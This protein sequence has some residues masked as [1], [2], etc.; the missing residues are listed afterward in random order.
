MSELELF[1]ETENFT[2]VGLSEHWLKPN[3]SEALQFKN[4][5]VKSHFSRPD[6]SHGGSMIL[7]QKP[8][9]CFSLDCIKLLSLE[10]HCEI[11]AI[12]LSK[13]NLVV[14]NIYR[15]PS[16][17]FDLFLEIL[18]ELFTNINSLT[19]NIILAG[20]FNVIF[21][22]DNLLKN[23]LC[24][25]M[26]CFGLRPIVDFPTRYQNRIDNVF[27]NID[28]DFYA[29]NKAEF[30]FTD[31]SGIKLNLTIPHIKTEQVVH[32]SFRPI[33]SIGKFRLFDMVEKIDWTFIDDPTTSCNA[34]FAKFVNLLSHL[35][36]LAFP[37]KI[38][39][40]KQSRD[41]KIEWYD[42]E[43]RA[44]REHL[45]NLSSIHNILQ[46]DETRKARNRNHKIYREKIKL[47]RINYNKKFINTAK[48]KC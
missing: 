46:T 45:L 21:N 9:H 26:H 27:T 47:T 3:E 19:K 44:M 15:P 5:V 14:I 42:D 28:S 12:T 31:H 30:L 38:F 37:V 25:F 48:N 22:T 41:I 23:R 35:A 43:L 40:F 8:F 4:Y 39:K 17:N 29:V 2:L 11:S 6:S 24:D 33:T 20:D 18:T 13:I 1:L 34:K 10:R 32:Q 36:N 7:C 16:G